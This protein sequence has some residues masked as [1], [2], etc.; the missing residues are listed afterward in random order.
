MTRCENSMRTTSPSP[1][2]CVS[3]A[4]ASPVSKSLKPASEG[5]SLTMNNVTST[6]ANSTAPGT[7]NAIV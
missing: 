6:H 3:P 2:R 7:Q 4:V 5:E 1:L